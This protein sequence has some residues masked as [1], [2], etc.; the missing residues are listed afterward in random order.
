MFMPTSTLGIKFQLVCSNYGLCAY[1]C[2]GHCWSSQ[3]L[4]SR[5]F[6]FVSRPQVPKLLA[7]VLLCLIFLPVFSTSPRLSERSILKSLLS[8]MKIQEMLE[9]LILTILPVFSTPM[10]C[11]SLHHQFLLPLAR[12]A[13]LPQPPPL[14]P[15]MAPS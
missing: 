3:M 15:A 6:R 9:T 10:S 13:A 4:T 5:M 11:F 1:I 12:L 2:E 7:T 14:T 8:T